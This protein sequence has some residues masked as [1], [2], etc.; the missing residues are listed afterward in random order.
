[1][2]SL[3][4]IILFLTITSTLN[5]QFFTEK[6]IGNNNIVSHN[7]TI[8]NYTKISILGPF[9]VH[10]HKGA[11][12]E[13]T[14]KSD[15]NIMEYIVTKVK[16]NTLTIR[17]KKGYLIRTKK[18]VEILVPFDKIKNISLTGSGKINT[19]NTINSSDL[20][21]SVVGSGN[22]NLRVHTEQLTSKLAGSG[23]I[24]LNG[25]SK[26]FTCDITGSG[27]IDGLQL[28]TAITTAKIA[29][30]GKI[31]IYATDEINIK[32]VGSGTVYYKGN[33]S[34]VNIKTTG[35][36]KVKKLS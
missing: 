33:P 27:A 23:K 26:T 10:L 3:A 25:N 24:N 18:T 8:T 30:S 22:I 28:Q 14:I 20:K 1:M 9:S 13:I 4:S 29:G 5:A 15:E 35:S 11:V 6:I 7:R 36:G 16:N 34:I 2:K 31:K 17:V 12:S 21:L 32:T 19:E